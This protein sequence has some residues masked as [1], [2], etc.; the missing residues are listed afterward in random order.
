MKF[1][2]D[3]RIHKASVSLQLQYG[4]NMPWKHEQSMK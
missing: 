3:F 4:S 1:I 2:P